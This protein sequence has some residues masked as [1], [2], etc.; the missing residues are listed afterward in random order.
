MIKLLFT[1]SCRYSFRL[2]VSATRS[3]FGLR[4]KYTNSGF[5]GGNAPLGPVTLATYSTAAS[6]VKPFD[7]FNVSTKS[8]IAT[9]TVSYSRRYWSIG[10][11]K[12]DIMES[13]ENI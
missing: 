3:P 8:P 10:L 4:L 7:T 2:P 12:I 6:C 11:V 13:S 5:F 1:L 9:F